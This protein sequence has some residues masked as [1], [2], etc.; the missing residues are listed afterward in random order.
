LSELNIALKIAGQDA[1]G[2]SL[3][4]SV[5]SGLTGL[6]SLAG[7]AVSV[8]L[9]VGLAD[10]FG[11]ATKAA[12]DFWN[13]ALEV[14]HQQ[15][16]LAASLK[17]TGD[18]SRMTVDSV[19]YLAD[20]YKDLAGGSD[21][22]VVAIEQVGIQAGSVTSGQ[23]PDFIQRVVDLGAV[24]GDTSAAALLLARA[25]EDP[26]SA[27]TKANK[28]GI[29]FSENLKD[30]VKNLVKQGETGKATALV[31][32][33][34]AEATSGAAASNARTL[35]GEWVILTNNL[36][37]AGRT[38]TETFL[39][40]FHDFME[41]VLLPAIPVVEKFAGQISGTLTTAFSNLGPSLAPLAPIL[42]NVQSA[43]GEMLSGV[44]SNDPG[45]LFK[46]FG[47][48]S[49]IF[50]GLWEQAQPRLSQFM[51]NAETW[52][53]TQLPVWKTNLEKWGSAFVDWAKDQWTTN[54]KPKLDQFIVDAKAWIPAQVPIWKAQLEAW[55]EAFAA[56]VDPIEKQVWARLW[57]L[58]NT[59]HAWIDM[60]VQPLEDKLDIWKWKFVF[61]VDDVWNH[62][63]EHLG[64][65]LGHIT[66]WMTTDAVPT[67]LV[68]DFLLAQ[69]MAKWAIDAVPQ[70][71]A[72]FI[73]MDTA[74]AHWIATDGVK[75]L[76]RFGGSFISSFIAGINQSELG[77]HVQGLI[78]D[79]MASAVQSISDSEANV[80]SAIVH[81]GISILVPFNKIVAD[82]KSA[83]DIKVWVAVGNDIANGLNQGITDKITEI[84]NNAAYAARQVMNAVE[85][86]FSIATSAGAGTAVAGHRASGGPVDAGQGYIVGEQGPEYFVPRQSGSIIPNGAGGAGGKTINVTFNYSGQQ[87]DEQSVVAALNKVAYLYG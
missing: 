48:L 34:I 25:N 19:N 86:A 84:A 85:S 7:G 18:A 36:E 49:S 31:L 57:I 29:L 82:I 10:A 43:F 30:Q 11:A 14:E 39:P 3:I 69:A 64:S 53:G 6:A 79:A 68:G 71:I 16:M 41:G 4:N 28:A 23:M 81:W 5:T 12:G 62:L 40:L 45:E 59:I 2:L 65:L 22:A 35:G 42:K 51:T 32:D 58:G 83:F 38:I 76:I 50:S 8:A 77:K 67:I 74:I 20:K 1:G 55:S 47:D 15:A 44:T 72:Y 63:P 37:D 87:L 24:M 33:R 46:G 52:I 60:E 26:V 54:V 70:I 17:S 73:Q 13:S 56:W 78:T 75:D 21:E 61:W 80:I 27:M 9:G 66:A